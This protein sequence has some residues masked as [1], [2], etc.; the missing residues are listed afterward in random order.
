MLTIE[1]N[2]TRKLSFLLFKRNVSEQRTLVFISSNEKKPNVSLSTLNR[3]IRL[4]PSNIKLNEIYYSYR[5]I[6]RVMFL[7]HYYVN[8]LRCPPFSSQKLFGVPW[9]V[10]MFWHKE[11]HCFFDIVNQKILRK[12]QISLPF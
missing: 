9:A 8:C 7:S 4:P 5:S 2:I 1:R 10:T 11:T 6:L 12:R 3:N